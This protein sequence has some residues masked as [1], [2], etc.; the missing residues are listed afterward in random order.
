MLKSYLLRGCLLAALPLTMPTVLMAPALSNAAT[1]A[2]LVNQHNHDLT[3]ARYL[4]GIGKNTARAVAFAGNGDVLA[5][6]NFA[7]LSTSGMT[8]SIL[9]GA[10]TQSPAKLLRLTPDGRQVLAQISLGNRIDSLQVR[11]SMMVVGGDFGVAVLDENFRPVWQN[12]LAGL[13]AG[14]GSSD[15]G[16][17]R[18]VMEPS[19]RV[20]VLRAK[21]VML[22]SDRGQQLA[23]KFIDR[24]YV[25]DIAIDP[26]GRR[27]YVVGFSNRNSGKP[28]QVS[29][30]H[31][32]DSQNGLNELWRT[33]DFAANLL[34][35]PANN[36]MADS[37]LYRVAVG[38]DGN[39]VVLGES[40]GGNSIYRW[41]GKDLTT[42]TQVKSD[43]YNDAYNTSSNH[44]LYYAKVNAADGIVT[45]GQFALGRLPKEKG[46]KGN[47]IRAK[48]G[49]LAVDKKGRI[50]IGG[51]AAYGIADRDV[52]KVNGIPVSPYA[53]SDMYFLMVSADLTQRL[54][55][56]VFSDNPK[57]GGTM[58][59]LAVQS[60]NVALFGTVEFGK[61]ITTNGQQR[62]N[63][64]DGKDTDAYFAILKN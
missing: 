63:S 56:T 31:A 19:G 61:M 37:R 55:W 14:N 8:Q 11:G 10:T 62:F 47:T 12:S 33:W 48:D 36:N 50:Y 16:Q 30:L 64:A 4:G 49:A 9:P 38:A 15:G 40:A 13:A 52:N 18:V 46:Y 41:N 22:F 44:I 51:V 3:Q 24:S 17:T 42:R 21:T 5:G 2:P 29:F 39:V 60:D 59:A 58:N 23:T 32:L 20:A 34:S 54:R 43:M 45:A 26:Y 7:N 28:V 27:V 35:N 53:G 57:G 6:G 25:N 1:P